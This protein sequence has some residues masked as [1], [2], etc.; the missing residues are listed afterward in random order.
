VIGIELDQAAIRAALDACLLS[1]D[2]QA[3]GWHKWRRFDD[4]FMA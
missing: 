4:P 2:E 3:F 1:D